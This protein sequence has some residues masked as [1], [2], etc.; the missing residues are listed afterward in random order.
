M[1]LPRPLRQFRGQQWAPVLNRGPPAQRTLRSNDNSS[2]S[3]LGPNVG[4][5]DVLYVPPLPQ[6][7][8]PGPQGSRR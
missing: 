6:L 3:S 1:A 7:S 2:E 4:G 5:Q 8:G